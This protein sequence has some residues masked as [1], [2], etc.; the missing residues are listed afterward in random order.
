[1]AGR[2]VQH[3]AKVQEDRD[4]GPPLSLVLIS[5]GYLDTVSDRAAFGIYVNGKKF[6]DHKL[7]CKNQL[8]KNG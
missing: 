8:L 4:H 6:G 2:T 5:T 1:M 7:F 3:P